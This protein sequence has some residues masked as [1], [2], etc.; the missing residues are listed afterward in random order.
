MNKSYMT[1]AAL[2]LCFVANMAVADV[3]KCKN[4]AGGWAYQE[5]PCKGL[6]QAQPVKI[7]AAPPASSG[8]SN[9]GTRKSADDAYQLHMDKEDYS[10]ALAF[11]TTEQQRSKALR[12]KNKKDVHC[13]NLKIKADQAH[14][15]ARESHSRQHAADAADATYANECR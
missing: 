9:P 4:E 1:C 13:Q 7:K 12:M 14:A 11:A 5:E 2:A 15:N 8:S 3:Y 6:N 10:G